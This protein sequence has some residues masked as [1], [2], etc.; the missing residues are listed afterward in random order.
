MSYIVYGE[1]GFDVE[2][3]GVEIASRQQRV[4]ER[5]ICMFAICCGTIAGL[6]TWFLLS[7]RNG[8][9]QSKPGITTD[10]IVR[11]GQ[12]ETALMKFDPRI[13]YLT[14]VWS[15]AVGV[16]IGVG[17]SLGAKGVAACLATGVAG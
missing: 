16:W 17:V 2:K 7:T 8:S 13:G 15:A 14:Q 10:I 6:A 12:R 3:L 5:G 11:P 1:K 9:L 4:K